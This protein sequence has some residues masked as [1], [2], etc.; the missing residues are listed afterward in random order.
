MLGSGL[1]LLAVRGRWDVS[2]TAWL[3][4]VFLLRFSRAS[5]TAAAVDVVWLEP[6]VAAEA[7]PIGTPSQE[8]C[9]HG[10]VGPGGLPASG[11][12]ECGL[13]PLD[14]VCVMPGRAVAGVRTTVWAGLELGGDP[15]EDVLSSVCGDELHPDR[16]VRGAPVEGQ[17]DGRLAREVEPR[18]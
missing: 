6:S 16:G 9:C 12:D 15:D 8:G 11:V 14:T 2:L 5:R 7:A 18:A 4:P 3:A 10:E 1:Y 13:R 17:A